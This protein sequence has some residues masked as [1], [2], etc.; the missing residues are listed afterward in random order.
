M[1][2]VFYAIN[3]YIYVFMTFSTSNCS[4][5]THLQTHGMYVENKPATIPNFVITKNI[6]VVV[7]V[8]CNTDKEIRWPF[9]SLT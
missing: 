6:V 2:V 7:V 1:I 5:M 9:C 8:Y 3:L 4:F